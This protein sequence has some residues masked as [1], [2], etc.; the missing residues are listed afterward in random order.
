MTKPC[1]PIK[2]PLKSHHEVF[3]RKVNGVLPKRILVLGG[4]GSGKSTLLA[5]IAYEWAMKDNESPL[6]DLPLLFVL[7]MR[8]MQYESDLVDAIFHQLLPRDTLIPK[9]CLRNFIGQNPDSVMILLDS[10]DEFSRG[11]VLGSSKPTDRNVMNVV[12]LLSYNYLTSCRILVSSRHWRASDF[13]GLGNIYAKIDIEGFSEGN[14]KGYIMRYFNSAPNVGERLYGYIKNNNLLQIASVPLMTQLFCLYWRETGESALPDKINDLYIEILQILYRHCRAKENSQTTV[15]F[16][17]IVLQLGRCA[18]L[19]LWPPENRL[20]FSYEE[21]KEIT[22]I[23]CIEDGCKTGIISIEKEMPTFKTSTEDE[24]DAHKSIVF[25]Y[26]SIQEKCAG[27]YLSHLANTQPDELIRKLQQLDTVQAYLSV[28]MI[29]R[30]A[31]GSS[32][33]AAG[34]ILEKLVEFAETKLQDEIREYHNSLEDPDISKTVQKF[35][36]VCLLC[37]YESGSNQFSQLLDNLFP[38]GKIQFLGL[39]P[40]VSD[41]VAHYLSCSKDRNWIKKIRIIQ[42]PKPG[43]F[44]SSYG[45][46]AA[47]STLEASVQDKLISISSYEEV[48]N[49]YTDY[50]EG[51]QGT[52][53]IQEFIRE[54]GSN[55]TYGL[56]YIGL[57]EYF[58]TWHTANCDINIDTIIDAV[59]FTALNE[60]DLSYVVLFDAG[61]RLV[62]AVEHGHLACLTHLILRSTGMSVDKMNRLVALLPQCTPRIQTLDISDNDAANSQVIQNLSKSLPMLSLKVLDICEMSAPASDMTTLAHIIPQCCTHLLELRMDLNYMD[63]ATGKALVTTL[64]Y[65]QHLQVLH[66]DV[67]G[68]SKKIHNKLVETMCKLTQLRDLRMNRS[69]Y[70][71]DLVLYVV[72]SLNLTRLT[73]VASYSDDH[74][75]SSLLKRLLRRVRKTE[76]TTDENVPVLNRS[77]FQSLMSGL[78]HKAEQM[79]WLDLWNIRLHEADFQALLTLCREHDIRLG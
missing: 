35:I 27:E 52:D 62:N 20:V 58:K 30:F 47:V 53:N 36:E 64:P 76:N 54:I 79:H 60:F 17:I 10:Y 21:V 23:Q 6:K 57:W 45:T 55:F 29:L 34:F 19:G 16:N 1:A 18:C 12:D 38:I 70:V 63:D 11:E 51:Y 56:L 22:S 50:V 44:Y 28:Q 41:A 67:D 9:H 40:C 15:P 13:S 33:K 77:S 31:C 69:P 2:I 3:T 4:G 25:F 74:C 48:R 32:L 8:Y 75:D 7:N 61:Q 78:Q 24:I 59:K 68:M 73:L 26:K 46:T 49:L 42:I 43:V 37:N 5:K 72:V 65:A 14:M 66:I 71:D 39:S